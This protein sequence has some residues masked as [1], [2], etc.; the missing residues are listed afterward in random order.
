MP[1]FLLVLNAGSSSLKFTLFQLQREPVTWMR[2]QL[3]GLPEQPRFRVRDAAGALLTDQ[4][5]PEEVTLDHAAAIR[6][7]FEWIGSHPLAQGRVVAAG[8]RVV[9]GGALFTHPVRVNSAVVDEL[10]RLIPLAPL[11]QSHHL[12]AI[13]A[14]SQLHPDL[15]QVA[16]FDTSFHATQPEAARMV[17][18]PQHFREE[19][20]QR[21]GFHGLS[22]EYISS[23]LPQCDPAAA[24]GRTIVAHLGNGVSLCALL[25]GRSIATTMGFSTLDGAVMGT[26]CGGIDPGVLL[27]LMDRHHFGSQELRKLLYQESGMLAVS[28]LSGDMRTLLASPDP[29]SAAAVELF[30]YRVRREI[31]SLAAALGGLD[32]V[33]F[34]GGIGENSPEVRRRV[35]AEGDWLGIQLDEAANSAGAG[36][37]SASGSRARVW[38]L[39]TNEELMIARHTLRQ[40]ESH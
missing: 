20:I 27:Y 18:L 35:C 7:L 24:A 39:P 25:A 10:E 6:V 11:H 22:Y 21:Y 16:C 36:R 8:H 3:D 14:V 5:W 26:R 31:G 1:D 2:G 32:A 37:I 19:G 17:P 9:H 34:T 4:V 13:R 28:E 12:A 29:R 33:V 38:V 15:P 40:L 23:I 30:V